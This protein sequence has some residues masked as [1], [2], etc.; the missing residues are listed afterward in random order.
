MVHLDCHCGAKTFYD[1]V[2]QSFL[3]Q[4]ERNN[5]QVCGSVAGV[6]A[7]Q[8]AVSDAKNKAQLTLKSL[9]IVKKINQD[10]LSANYLNFFNVSQFFTPVE[11]LK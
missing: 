2:S 6:G 4:K 1:E 3:P 11:I 7:W 9:G 5:R 10:K 8:D